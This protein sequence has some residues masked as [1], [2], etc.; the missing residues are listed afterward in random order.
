MSP[1]KYFVLFEE[2]Y[3]DDFNWMCTSSDSFV[4]ELRRELGDKCSFNYCDCKM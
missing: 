2:K 4:D 3:G 1:D